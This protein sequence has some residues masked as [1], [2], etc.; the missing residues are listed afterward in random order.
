MVIYRYILAMTYARTMFLGLTAVMLAAGE[1]TAFP[2]PCPPLAA[3]PA[4]LAAL[5]GSLG[6]APISEADRVRVADGHFIDAA[7][8]RVRLAGVN[9]TGGACFPEAATAERIA[10][11]LRAFGINAVRIHHI[12][13]PWA[14]PSIF[15]G[16]GMSYGK[17]TDQLDPAMAA[18]LAGFLAALGRHGVYVDLNL[19]VTRLFQAVDGFPE[20]ERLP[21]EGKIVG[22]FNEQA[23]RQQEAYARQIL[24]VRTPEGVRIADLPNLAMIEI[25]NEDSLLFAPGR[26][27]AL[28]PSYHAELTAGW[29][30]W[31]K[32]T[33]GSTAAML[34]V[35]NR[36]AVPL[37]EDR[38]DGTSAWSL[39][40]HGTAAALDASGG[41]FRLS[42]L[43]ID[44]THWHLQI[45]RQPLALADGDAVTLSF[46]ARADGG[47]NLQVNLR[48]A[49]DPWG[50][51][52]L[53]TT[54]SI[55]RD[56]R[57]FSF[58]CSV[59]G[60]GGKPSRLSFMAGDHAANIEVADVQL[61]RGNARE[62]PAGQTIEQ[63]S[64]ALPPVAGNPPG[65]DAVAYLMAVEASYGRRMRGLLRDELR[66]RTPLGISQTGFGGLPG[67]VREAACDFVDQHSYWDHPSFPN[68]WW[69][70]NDWRTGNRCM[71][72][73]PGLGALDGMAKARVAGKPATLT[74]Y[75][76]PAPN[77]Y[78]AEGV[79]LLFTAAALQDWDAVFLFSWN[80]DAAW[81]KQHLFGF[82]DAAN[83][84]G[85]LAHLAAFAGLFRSGVLVP[86]AATRTLT[87][88]L[89]AVPRIAAAGGWPNTWT[90]AGAAAIPE[91]PFLVR[92]AVR[93]ADGDG[94]PALQRVGQAEPGAVR[95][96]R[97]R[98]AEM[99]TVD[100]PQLASVV[101]M[102]GGRT[103][104]LSAL[105]LTAAPTPRGF[106]SL[107]A[108]SCDGQPLARSRRI[109]LAAID[110]AENAGWTW[111][112]ER[113]FI[114]TAWKEGPVVVHG[115]A[116]EVVLRG[117]GASRV[118]ALA[119][120]GSVAAE[121][122]STNGPDGLTF[123]IDPAQ[124]ALW[125]E[126]TSP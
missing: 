64:V 69:D 30:A 122:P 105:R 49:G 100:L 25:N 95:W 57:S 17:K 121:I 96:D 115:F 61:R 34:A 58:P 33:Y 88:P 107:S 39:E 81:D 86:L 94:E 47:R 12:D 35:W 45:H 60:T 26:L 44:G 117:R 55:D 65:Q 75:N 54:V 113:S 37:G 31:L 7:G 120:D 5:G 91:D 77:E 85:Q 20:A 90:V 11:R 108:A 104:T 50:F 114:P 84:P 126:I 101:G 46:R 29:N 103:V 92:W 41:G 52:G 71:L 4:A 27:Q 124:R 99:L 98:G 14:V 10:A 83:H 48:N 125:Y 43:R 8:R 87:V 73:D 21:E 66:V 109:L 22:Y 18:R 70:T 79:P 78:L 13:A 110:K 36:G 59:A 123:R 97:T 38:L 116:A 67:I 72:R 56:W 112:A 32:E 74:E 93:L 62:L 28:P 89:A 6:P 80:G 118:R 106:L 42:G 3:P 1:A 40:Q 102:A 19:K 76:H 63:A 82:F 2:Y 53:D 119:A 23:I 111:N 9:I 51:V 15:R 16:D 68:R 24:A